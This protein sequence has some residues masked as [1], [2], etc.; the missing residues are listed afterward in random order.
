MLHP[1]VVHRVVRAKG[2]TFRGF[3][4]TLERLRGTDSV[5]ATL[6]ELP[7]EISRALRLGE[8]VATGW[9]PVDWYRE[10]HAA[11]NRACRET[12][13]ELSRRIGLE[14]TIADFRGIYRLLLRVVSSET[15]VSQSPRLLAMFFEGGEVAMVETGKGF[16]VIEFTGWHGFDRAMWADMT[17]AVEGVL[18]ARR[19][20]D[21]RTRVL[22]GGGSEGMLRLECRWSMTQPLANMI[23]I[24][25]R[26]PPPRESGLTKDGGVRLSERPAANDMSERAANDG[27]RS[28]RS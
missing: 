15:L 25:T 19:A 16:G 10:L 7:P 28:R 20:F 21:I 17:G 8:V 26:P 6:A 9:Y 11:M 27:N 23:K 12:G 18:V 13:F 24:S 2:I 5:E 4:T 22:R 3:L 1:T 14:S